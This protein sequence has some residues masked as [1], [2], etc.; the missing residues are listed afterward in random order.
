[1]ND[2]SIM[3]IVVRRLGPEA[4][5]MNLRRVYNAVLK[6]RQEADPVL[7]QLAEEIRRIATEPPAPAD[8]EADT[9]LPR[10]FYR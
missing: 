10:G 6:T 5:F 1:M 8:W 2:Y 3:K 7:R 4:S 9:P